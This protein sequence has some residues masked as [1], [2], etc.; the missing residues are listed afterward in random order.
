MPLGPVL[1]PLLLAFATH[2]FFP[3]QEPL[4]GPEELTGLEGKGTSASV[5]PS[6]FLSLESSKGDRRLW[7]R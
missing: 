3:R 2:H 5:C 6:F 7:P 1:S 4:I